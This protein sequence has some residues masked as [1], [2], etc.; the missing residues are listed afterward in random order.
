MLGQK[1]FT[2]CILGMHKV[3]IRTRILYRYRIVL[4][5]S[6]KYIW[7]W[8][9]YIYP[10]TQTP[11]TIHRDSIHIH[12]THTHTTHTK[13]IYKTHKHTKYI[14]NTHTQHTPNT[15][16]TYTHN[17]QQIHTLICTQN[18][19]VFHKQLCVLFSLLSILCLKLFIPQ[20]FA[21]CEAENQYFWI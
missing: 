14:N 17:T 16:I 12:T 19:R 10:F 11:N 9:R 8:P 2:K 1:S 18:T 21:D 3:W 13:Y 4:H 15:H 5:V 7:K 6:R 20:H